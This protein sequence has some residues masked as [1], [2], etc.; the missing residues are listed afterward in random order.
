M[1]RIQ[2]NRSMAGYVQLKSISEGG[3]AST[4]P[5][6]STFVSPSTIEGSASGDENDGS[7]T[8]GSTN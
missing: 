4:S 7:G 3:F 1:A 5:V 6:T 2:P 8:T